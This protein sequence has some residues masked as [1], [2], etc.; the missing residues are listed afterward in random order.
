MKTSFLDQIHLLLSAVTFVLFCLGLAASHT[1]VNRS[2]TYA[3]F[4]YA[5]GHEQY[6]LMS[7]Q[8]QYASMK[9]YEMQPIINVNEI[10]LQDRA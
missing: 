9:T 5:P 4:D 2:V 8:T 3:M 6:M 7:G 10:Q 1:G